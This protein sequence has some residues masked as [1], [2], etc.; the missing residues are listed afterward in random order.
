MHSILIVFEKEEMYRRIYPGISNQ[1]FYSIKEAEDF[2]ILFEIQWPSVSLKRLDEVDYRDIYPLKLFSETTDEINPIKFMEINNYD[3]IIPSFDKISK[4]KKT[5]SR[6]KIEKGVYFNYYKCPCDVN[7]VAMRLTI[8]AKPGDSNKVRLDLIERSFAWRNDEIEG[9]K[10][11]SKFIFYD[12]NPPMLSEVNTGF[13][14]VIFSTNR[15]NIM[16]VVAIKDYNS[17]FS[18]GNSIVSNGKIYNNLK[19]FYVDPEEVE[20]EGIIGYYIVFVHPKE[21]YI[22]IVDQAPPVDKIYFNQLVKRTESFKFHE[23]KEII[24]KIMMK[25]LS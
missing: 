16:Q 3:D 2:N 14:N 21:D 15:E 23:L 8:K 7:D 10:F 12:L 19:L 20:Q 11:E 24:M 22:F 18:I 6:V 5:L 1:Y 4:G 13:L 17:D 9:Q 25:N